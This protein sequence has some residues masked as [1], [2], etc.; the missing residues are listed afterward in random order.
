MTGLPRLEPLPLPYMVSPSVPFL[1]VSTSEVTSESPTMVSFLA[2]HIDGA[3]SR[4]R[5]VFERGL[6]V[7]FSPAYRRRDRARGRLRLVGCPAA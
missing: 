5:I 7:R 4:A 1:E 2:T 6:W 3:S